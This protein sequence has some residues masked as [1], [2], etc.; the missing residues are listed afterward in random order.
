MPRGSVREASR[1]SKLLGVTGKLRT[2]GLKPDDVSAPSA[3][4]TQAAEC[5]IA[6][7]A[8]TAAL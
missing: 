6:S 1:L 7:H 4:H 5:R 3:R 8:D 2:G